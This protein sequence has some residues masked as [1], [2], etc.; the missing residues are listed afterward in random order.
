MNI[1]SSADKDKILL[2]PGSFDSTS[3]GLSY[4]MLYSVVTVNKKLKVSIV[5][6]KDKIIKELIVKES[7]IPDGILGY[8]DVKSYHGYLVIRTVTTTILID[9]K[10]YS[11]IPIRE[12]FC[13]IN[14]D[15]EILNSYNSLLYYENRPYK[16]NLPYPLATYYINMY[17]FLMIGI[18]N[19][20]TKIFK[21]YNL[22][23]EFLWGRNVYVKKI[24]YG[25][26]GILLNELAQF[27]FWET[28]DVIT[29]L[30]YSTISEATVCQNDRVIFSD[31]NMIVVWDL[32]SNSNTKYPFPKIVDIYPDDKGDKVAVNTQ[33]TEMVIFYL[34]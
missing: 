9:L 20:Q 18:D 11:I 32:K 8:H 4:D 14:A 7:S 2:D 28:G 12:D 13:T 16:E 26:S 25:H 17:G 34:P 1:E 19:Y 24:T 22:N 3:T 27:I 31:L 23:D 6:V 15:G 10:T 30:E 21:F 29:N 33:G 5:N